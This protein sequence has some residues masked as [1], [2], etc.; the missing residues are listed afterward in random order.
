MAGVPLATVCGGLS[1]GS[2][3]VADPM[4]TNRPQPTSFTAGSTAC[5]MYTWLIV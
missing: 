2:F 4:C 1:W 3:A 5:S